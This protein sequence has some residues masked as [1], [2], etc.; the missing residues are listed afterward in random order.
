MSV[1]IVLADD[2]KIVRDG[3]RAILAQETGFEIV[4]EA[5]D[6]QNA[7]ALVEKHRPDI[8]V[9]D[10]SMPGLNGI[11]AARK[12]AG[13]TPPIRVLALSMHTDRHFISEM[14]RAGASGYL[15]KDCAG[16]E[17]GLAIRTIVGGKTYL[18]PS[19]SRVIVDEFV[20]R[21]APANSARAILTTRELEVLQRLA[22]GKSIKEIA[23]ELNVSVKTVETHRAKISEKLGISSI[24]ELTK[25]ALREGI[26][27]LEF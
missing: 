20:N 27:S 9:M 14:L 2:H 24:A 11:E 23:F 25:Y 1:R 8:V 7:L 19:V 4:A 10:I 12:M 26:T 5:G 6:G 22:E 16:E 13:L 17:L 15:L 18:S 21:G 3:L